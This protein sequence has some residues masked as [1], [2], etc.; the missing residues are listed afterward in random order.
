MK[1]RPMKKLLLLTVFLAMLFLCQG[2]YHLLANAEQETFTSPEGTNTIIVQYDLVCRPTI[3]KRG[4]PWNRKI[5]D[6]PGSGFMETVHF[7][8]EWLSESEIRLTYDD[9]ND[10]FDE[11]YLITIPD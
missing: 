9:V 11:E 8:V 2:C 4:W 1:R 3:Y 7:G 10:K 6:Y 5:W